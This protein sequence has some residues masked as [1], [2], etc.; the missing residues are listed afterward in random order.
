MRLIED[1]PYYTI[2]DLQYVLGYVPEASLGLQYDAEYVYPVAQFTD[3][4][5][6]EPSYVVLKDFIR[7]HAIPDKIVMKWLSEDLPDNPYNP[8]EWIIT[9][10]DIEKV[11]GNLLSYFRTYKKETL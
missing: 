2:E 4:G 8:V 9:H 3:D 7:N 1:I 6:V 10:H 5:K 11:L